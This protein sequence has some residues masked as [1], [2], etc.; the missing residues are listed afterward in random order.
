MSRNFCYSDKLVKIVIVAEKQNRM[1]GVNMIVPDQF[2]EFLRILLL[3]MKRMWADL[4]G[5]VAQGWIMDSLALEKALRSVLLP[6]DVPVLAGISKNLAKAIDFIVC[7]NR[8][9]RPEYPEWKKELLH[10]ELECTGPR[11]FDLSKAEQWLHDGQ[12]GNST[13][14]GQVIYEYLK[15]NNML[16]SCYSLQDGLA[17]QRK[18][19]AVFR[20]LFKGKAVFLWKSVV[21]DR[22]GL[23]VPCLYESGDMVVECWDRLGGS[24]GSIGPALRHGK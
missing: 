22:C 13:T 21:R 14:T 16:D 24:W 9:V 5:D 17:I 23:Y 3:V 6:A 8:K 2:V 7:V 18:G 19:I 1:G 10:P 4:E 12:K 15:S 20:E 11:K